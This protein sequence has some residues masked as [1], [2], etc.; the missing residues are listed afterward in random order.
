MQRRPRKKSTSHENGAQRSAYDRGLGLLMRREYSRRELRARLLRDG[1][2]ETEAD[3]ALTRLSQQE[4]QNDARFAEMI[5]RARIA[6]GYGPTRIRAEL[7]SHGLAERTIRVLIDGAEADW[8]ALAGAQ[9]RKKY[10]RKPASD[11][12]ERGK[13]VD[14]LLRRGFAAATVRVVTHAYVDD[15]GALD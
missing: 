7:R 8:E 1:G 6:Q 2:E 12:A 13:G 15:A 11:H 4:Y 10:G 14:F 3:E 9:L 5:L